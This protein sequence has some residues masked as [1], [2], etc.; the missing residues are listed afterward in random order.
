LSDQKFVGLRDTPHPAHLEK[1]P[2]HLRHRFE[3]VVECHDV[4]A[5][6]RVVEI[7]TGVVLLPR[8]TVQNKIAQGMLA[9]VPPTG[10][11]YFQL[12]AVVHREGRKLTP[13]VQAF[14]EFLKRPD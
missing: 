12:Q 10:E 11:K 14:I 1:L 7:G 9:A 3:P 8:G 5:V 13:L 6:V 4:E 2:G